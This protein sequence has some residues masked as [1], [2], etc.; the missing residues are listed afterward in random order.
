MSCLVL[1]VCVRYTIL[2][3]LFQFFKNATE[4]SVVHKNAILYKE[5]EGKQAILSRRFNFLEM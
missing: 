5:F 2:E 4:K 3:S 1:F